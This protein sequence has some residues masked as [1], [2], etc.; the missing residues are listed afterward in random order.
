MV[1]ASPI[2]NET[3]A[4]VPLAGDGSVAAVPKASRLEVTFR[5][6]SELI[7]HVFMGW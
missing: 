2:T 5:M 6:F 4:P 1:P 7:H 3:L